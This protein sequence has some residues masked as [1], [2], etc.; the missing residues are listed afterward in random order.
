M[1]RYIGVEWGPR[2]LHPGQTENYIPAIGM[3]GRD[4]KT[5]MP[6]R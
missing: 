3:A 6:V 4:P 2:K 5:G 1:M